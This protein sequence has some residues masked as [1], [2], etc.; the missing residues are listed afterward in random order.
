[1]ETLDQRQLAILKKITRQNHS[2]IVELANHLKVSRETVRKELLPLEKDGIVLRAKGRI[3]YRD[4]QENA[5]LLE[6]AGV[7]SKA[8]RHKRILQMLEQ[9]QELRITT[10]ADKLKVSQITIRNDLSTMEMSG[11]I[12]RKHGAATLLTSSTNVADGVMEHLS[13]RTRILGQHTLMHINPGETIFLDSGEV[14]QFVAKSLPPYSNIPIVTNSLEILDILRGRNYSYP[15]TTT[16]TSISIGDNRIRMD[17]EATQTPSWG[18]DKAFIGC[19]SYASHT[20]F[21]S[22]QEHRDTIESVCTQAQRIYLT[23]DSRYLDVQ[24]SNSFD[25]IKFR[26]KLQEVSVD[27]GIGSFQASVLFSHQDPL[28]VCGEDYTY[29]NVKRQK[30]R[31]GFLVNKDRNHFVQAVHNSL[32]EATS[33]SNSVSLV[34]RECN[35]DYASTVHN[36]NRL[37]EEH[38]DLIIDYSL[39]ME[40]LM[41]VG[42]RCLA[43]H[44]K[45]ISVDYM[46]PG[47]IYFGADNAL[48]GKIAGKQASEYMERHWE[49]KLDKLLVLDNHGHDPIT[50]LRISSALEYIQKHI[51]LDDSA[52]HTIEWGTP[53]GNPIKELV[54]LLKNFPAQDRVLIIAFNL[55]HL[56]AAY[57]VIVQHRT[58]ENTIIVG[59]NHT[60]QIEEFMKMD[61]S[62]IIGCVHYN[63]QSYGQKIMDLALRML[64]DVE[65]PLRNYTELRLITRDHISNRQS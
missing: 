46:A 24:G 45:L 39:C 14:S 65:V 33:A 38:V 58:T 21:L 51:A 47:A 23:L 48:A 29:R 44:I 53:Q 17:R 37:L 41:Y 13:V 6:A 18:I 49:G 15:I 43:K 28:V 35:G 31:I 10:L 1:M 64:G 34:I 2:T 3:H 20:Y 36:L 26:H 54:G 8:Q 56:L 19:A 57:D 62:P 61:N 32:L 40:S 12:I 27:D 4:T 63:P 55:R 22:A 11:K 9:E 25:H 50:K 42:E 60:K 30:Y 59:Q 7:L 16:G 5:S 52:M